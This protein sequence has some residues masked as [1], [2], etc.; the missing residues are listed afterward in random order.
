VQFRILGPLEVLDDG[1]PLTLGGAK[2]RAL[3]AVLLLHAGQ[4]V[5][6]ERLVDELWGEDPPERAAHIL[7]VHVANLR[8]VLEPARARRAAGGVLRTRPP[9]YLVEVGP[10]ELDLGRFERL[11]AEG[12]AALA[13]GAA[14]KAA[15]LLRSAL[16][17]WRGG[18]PAGPR[19]RHLGQRRPGRGRPAGGA[20]PG[21]S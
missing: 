11:A 9:G 4:V 10:D 18:E 7:Q 15:G 2:Q 1:R 14:D 17:L 6:L 21:G 8:K 3:L 12:R 16:A 19:R 20:P 13:A 5:P